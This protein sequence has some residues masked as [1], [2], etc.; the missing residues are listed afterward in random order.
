MIARLPSVRHRLL[1]LLAVLLA[2]ATAG[3]GSSWK[4]VPV[5]SVDESTQVLGDYARFT[6]NDQRVIELR[7]LS[8]RYPFVEGH[9]MLGEWSTPRRM[10]VDLREVSRIEV[11]KTAS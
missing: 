2:L 1:P 10:R 4:A 6:L 9:R 3:C 11:R 8:V 5:G 7:V